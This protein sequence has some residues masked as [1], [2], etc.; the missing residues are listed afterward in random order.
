MFQNE[1]K[2][3]T[4]T[5]WA[6]NAIVKTLSN[7]HSPNILEVGSG[8]LRRRQ[9]D[10]I[11]EQSQTE[12]PCHTMCN[13]L[14]SFYTTDRRVMSMPEC[15]SF[16]A[17]HLMQKGESMRLQAAEHPKFSRDLTSVFDY[18]TGRKLRKDAKG[19]VTKKWQECSRGA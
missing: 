6:D 3:L 16:L 10:G 5:M 14:A 7:F 9:V 2:K 15:V 17:H 13:A 19:V 8:V 18:G 4:Y 12:V 11:R 1:N